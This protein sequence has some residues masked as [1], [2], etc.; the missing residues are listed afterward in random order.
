MHQH[1]R[2]SSVVVTP[3]ISTVSGQRFLFVCL[4]AIQQVGPNWA[5]VFLTVKLLVLFFFF[6]REDFC[7]PFAGPD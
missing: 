1:A 4:L 7:L 5:E 3:V 2:R 6:S